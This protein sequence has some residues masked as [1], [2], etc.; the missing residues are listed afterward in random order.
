MRPPSPPH[1]SLPSGQ[2]PHRSSPRPLSPHSCSSPSASEGGPQRGRLGRG[3]GEGGSQGSCCLFSGSLPAPHAG[4][5]TA[6]HAAAHGSP[7]PRPRGQSALRARQSNQSRPL[8]RA[9]RA[10]SGARLL[11]SC[12][13]RRPWHLEAR[14]PA[15]VQPFSPIRG[16]ARSGVGSLGVRA[17]VIAPG[18]RQR[19]AGGLVS[20]EWL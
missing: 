14:T 8:G 2:G 6:Q 16:P 5:H 17:S 4:L 7:P 1:N 13:A 20:V 10:S 15:W 11:P 9:G 12:L 18:S 19:D 3:P